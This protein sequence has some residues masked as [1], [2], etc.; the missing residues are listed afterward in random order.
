MIIVWVN[1]SRYMVHICPF[2][3]VVEIKWKKIRLLSVVGQLSLESFSKTYGRGMLKIEPN[4]LKKSLVYKDNDP[5]VNT[6]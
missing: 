5:E 4:T 3:S 6:F 1:K 2:P